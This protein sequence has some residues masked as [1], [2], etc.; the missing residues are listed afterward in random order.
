[1]KKKGQKKSIRS[2]TTVIETFS[3]TRKRRSK[4]GEKAPTR[5]KKNDVLTYLSEK[6]AREST[7]KEKKLT[8]RNRICSKETRWQQRNITS[9]KDK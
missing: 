8:K 6:N 1:M 2:S 7:S 5:S 9:Y 3:Q 4:E